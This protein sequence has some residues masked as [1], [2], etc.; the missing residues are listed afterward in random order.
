MA[1]LKESTVE[2]KKKLAFKVSL[3]TGI[4]VNSVRCFQQEESTRRHVTQLEEIRRKAMEMRILR[5][6]SAE[7]HHDSPTPDERKLSSTTNSIL[8][9]EDSVV[10]RKC[11]TLCNLLVSPAGH[12]SDRLFVSSFQLASDLHLQTHLRGTR[13]NQLL[14]ER[15]SQKPDN[16]SKK[17]AK[18]EEIVTWFP[19]WIF[20]V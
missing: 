18:Q 2:L 5:G 10:T 1:G 17:P 19:P 8:P 13:H 16:G 7:D 15:F 12:P 14:L 20:D 11:C 3:V 4:N 9:T 6:P